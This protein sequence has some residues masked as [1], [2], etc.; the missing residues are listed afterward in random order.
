MLI[1]ILYFFV[2]VINRI[3]G[4]PLTFSHDGEDL[5]LRKYLAKIENG[6]YIDIGANAPVWGSNTFYFYLLGWR[7]VCLDPLPNLKNKYR[8]IRGKDKFINAAIFGSK[9]KNQNK[10]NFYYYKTHKDNS[11]FDQERVQQLK[12]NFGREPS[13]IISVPKISTQ[14]M[15]S[16]F[17]NFF[18][19]S[20]EIHLLNIDIEGF[21][22]DILEDFFIC[23]TYPWI[24]C[25]EEIGQTA[26]SLKTKEIYKL[27][28]KN[29][30]MLGS[31][32]FL[33][34]FYVLRSKLKELPSDFVKEL[35]I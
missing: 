1:K 29:G 27:M 11:T 6:K 19:Q 7:G 2:K 8:L 35:D 15:L 26:E 30:Y 34:S 16:T 23:N 13:S 3:S 33:S 18:L 10:L 25:V 24:V 17:K 4:L 9:S 28:E 5:V 32:T 14:E 12:E 31:R 21:E 20:K 22:I